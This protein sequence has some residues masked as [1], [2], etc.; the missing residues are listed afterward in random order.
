MDFN[1]IKAT[2]T[3]A[4]SG[5]VVMDPRDIRNKT[6]ETSPASYA[7]IS[8]DK[9]VAPPGSP[10]QRRLAPRQSC[11]FG[12]LRARNPRKKRLSRRQGLLQR[13]FRGGGRLN[14][15]SSCAKCPTSLEPP[16]ARARARETRKKKD[17][18]ADKGCCDGRF[19]GA[20]PKPCVFLR[21]MSD[22]SRTS[23]CARARAKR[24]KKRL[25]RRQG[26]LRRPFRGGGPE[27]LRLLARNVRPVSNLPLRARA[28]KTRKKKTFAH[29]RAS[30]TAVS[31]GRRRNLASSC[32]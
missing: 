4:S 17:F 13:P 12:V 26:L 22:Q 16:I 31:G 24:E 9:L 29:T 1:Q 21:V 6:P 28:R 8:V 19:G 10:G 30:A 5:L 7:R 3:R 20:A 25:S 11:N 15:A 2:S 23:H 18:R 14:L 32:A 27:T